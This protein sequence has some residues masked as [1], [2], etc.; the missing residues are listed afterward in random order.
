MCIRDRINCA[1]FGISGAVEFTSMEQA[2]AQFDVNFFGTVTAVSYTH[3]DVYKRQPQLMRVSY[4]R[5]VKARLS[6]GV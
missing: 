2:K 1:G 4:I 5:R 6:C 3:L